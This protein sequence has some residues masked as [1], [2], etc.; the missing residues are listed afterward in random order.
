[1]R[2]LAWCLLA[3]AGCA[4][5]AAAQPADGTARS[6]DPRF[7]VFDAVRGE[8]LAPEAFWSAFAAR[9]GGRD[10]GRGADYPPYAEV[11]EFDTFLVEID[12]ETCLMQFFHARWRLANDVQRWNQRL[13][14]YG[15]CPRV[16]E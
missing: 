7:E 13:N 9:S 11:G 1:M 6:A 8:W 12:G 15:A 16:F 2:S 3:V 10:W 4:G 5:A 14:D